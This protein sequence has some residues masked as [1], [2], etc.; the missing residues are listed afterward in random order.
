MLHPYVAVE[1]EM[2]RPWA[3]ADLDRHDASMHLPAPSLRFSA[4]VES[5]LLYTA[6]FLRKLDRMMYRLVR[7]CST[8][9]V[10]CFDRPSVF[11]VPSMFSE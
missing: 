7:M 6:A 3:F 11:T 8:L 4:P 1:R 2:A 9:S 5:Q 10:R